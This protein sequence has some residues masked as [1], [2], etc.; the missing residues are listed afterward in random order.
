VTPPIIEEDGIVVVPP[1]LQDWIRVVFSGTVITSGRGTTALV[2]ETGMN[3]EMGKTQA[4]P[5]GVTKVKTPLGIRLDDF[6]GD[7]MTKTIGVLICILVWMVSIPKLWDA[8]FSS[9]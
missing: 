6:G 9:P 4:P 2:L 7:S 3:T 8:W 1:P 5:P